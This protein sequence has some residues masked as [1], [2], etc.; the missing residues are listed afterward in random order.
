MGFDIYLTSDLELKD[1]GRD[2]QD[3]IYQCDTFIDRRYFWFIEEYIFNK[4]YSILYQLESLL[5]LPLIWLGNIKHADEEYDIETE[6]LE[7]NSSLEKLYKIQNR[8]LAGVSVIGKLSFASD[9]SLV[10]QEY[11]PH[12]VQDGAFLKDIQK[13]TQAIECYQKAGANRFLMW[14]G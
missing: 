13:I 10:N 9:M 6:L 1:I 7:I 4:E 2:P 8:F 5:D 3:K 12:Y 14:W 11:Y